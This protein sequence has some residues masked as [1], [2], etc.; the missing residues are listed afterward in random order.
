MHRVPF[1]IFQTYNCKANQ[2]ERLLLEVHRKAE[3]FPVPH[4]SALL[5]QFTKTL[6]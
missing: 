5:P 3:A 4:V 6:P 2:K 1:R